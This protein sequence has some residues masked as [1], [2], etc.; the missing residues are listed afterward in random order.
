M[1]GYSVDQR[2]S[3][4]GIVLETDLKPLANYVS[5]QKGGDFWF[6]SGTGPSV[7]GRLGENMTAAEG[8]QAARLAGINLLSVLRIELEGDWDRLDQI[9]KVNGYVNCTPDFY[10][11]PEVINGTS[12]LLVEVLG[13]RG[14]HARTAVGTNSLPFRI[15]VEVEMI[16][17]V[18]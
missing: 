5:V 3:E 4:L 12:D 13:E 17:R 18:K 2:L 16:V 1:S 15:P 6:F 9:I 11:Q 8:Y 14:R 10:E 7:R